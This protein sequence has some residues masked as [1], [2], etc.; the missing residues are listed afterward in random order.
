MLLI[1]P[2]SLPSVGLLLA[3]CIH[4][5][6]SLHLDNL[7]NIPTDPSLPFT[8]YYNLTSYRQPGPED[9][10]CY[11][12]P[13]YDRIT[14]DLCNPSL[15]LLRADAEAVPGPRTWG[16]GGNM[17]QQWEA[18]GSGCRI[19]VNG[20]WDELPFHGQYRYFSYALVLRMVIT[21][22]N[23]CAI[24]QGMP[25]QGGYV[26]VAP[27]IF[28]AVF[29]S[30]YQNGGGEG[31]AEWEVPPWNKTYVPGREVMEARRG[32]GKFLVLAPLPRAANVA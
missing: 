26:E 23:S 29:G 30:S 27:R 24:Q 13:W 22:L 32:D 17:G 18:I 20:V 2:L 4:L 21:L 8:A 28:A 6:T 15:D 16:H 5:S 19:G 31:E 25:G 14:V 9:Y 3:I 7:N 10:R 12:G 1:P 11:N